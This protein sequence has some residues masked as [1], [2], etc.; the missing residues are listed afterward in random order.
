MAAL[1]AAI[2]QPAIE[3]L[4][5]AFIARGRGAT[6]GRS[7]RQPRSRT[8]G[9][10]PVRTPADGGGRRGQDAVDAG[11]AVREHG[12]LGKARPLYAASGR[13]T[14]PRRYAVGAHRRTRAAA[15][16][17]HRLLAA[18]R[19]VGARGR[20]AMVREPVRVARVTLAMGHKQA[21]C[22]QLTQ[23]KPAMPACPTPTC[24]RSS[25]PCTSRRVGEDGTRDAKT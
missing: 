21:S 12:D 24:A 14:P 10:A 20:S 6:A 13:A 1:L 18:T 5:V 25:T 19:S 22:E 11:A 16:R 4:A 15:C 8:G 17:R 9:P 3:D 2:G 7:R 23:L